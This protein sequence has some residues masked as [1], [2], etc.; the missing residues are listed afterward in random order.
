MVDGAS[1][2]LADEV[3]YINRRAANYS[4]Q[5]SRTALGAPL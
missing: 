3:R 2:H 1:F 4:K 5:C